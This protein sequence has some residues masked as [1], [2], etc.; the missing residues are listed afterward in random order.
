MCG[1]G[2]G[3][4][5]QN[6]SG[7]MSERRALARQHS[8]K[9]NSRGRCGGE[10]SVHLRAAG[11]QC[12]TARGARVGPRRRLCVSVASPGLFTVKLLELR[13]RMRST[14]TLRGRRPAPP[15]PSP[16]PAL[17]VR[18]A[19]AWEPARPTYARASCTPTSMT[20]RQNGFKQIVTT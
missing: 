9:I 1:A 3:Y 20:T 18:E 11:L 17:S 7:V 10:H 4:V 8:Q 6:Q 15:P 2:A 19:S 13:V 14:C 12:A 5:R 16:T